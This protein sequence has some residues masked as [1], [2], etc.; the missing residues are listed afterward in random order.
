MYHEFKFIRVGTEF[1]LQSKHRFN[2][3]TKSTLG[4]L[5]LF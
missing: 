2:K 1:M 5:I 3:Q 4:I